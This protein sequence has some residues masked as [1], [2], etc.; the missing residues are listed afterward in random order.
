[1]STREEDSLLLFLETC[2]VD[3]GYVDV[4]HMN[5]EDM[6]IAER[7]NKDGFI[8]FRRM[9]F[10]W[11]EKLGCRAGKRNTH[12]VVFTPEAF[13]IAHKLRCERAGRVATKL[14]ETRKQY[15]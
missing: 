14:N 12:Y 15:L 5:T 3:F 7:W 9:P 11:I 10:R 1:M 2:A 8:I 4:R 6:I 13:N